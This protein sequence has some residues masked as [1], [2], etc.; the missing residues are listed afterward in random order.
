MKKNDWI[1]AGIVLI[2]TFFFLAGNSFFAGRNKDTEKYVKIKI[3]GKVFGEINLDEDEEI[4]LG[5]HNRIRIE[6][7]E[8]SMIWAD[9]PDQ[10]CVEHPN[11]SKNHESIICLPNKVILEIV[12]KADKGSKEHD[13]VAG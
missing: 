6:D 7:G 11:I 3:D 8:V 5:E 12:D 9:C 10:I 2:A 1:L 13:A 4:S